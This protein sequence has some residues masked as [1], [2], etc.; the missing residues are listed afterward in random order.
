VARLS[1]VGEVLPSCH[2]DKGDILSRQLFKENQ[3]TSVVGMTAQ[4]NA[5][6]CAESS[7]EIDAE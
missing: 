1:L 7:A 4:T 5:V 2:V 6:T 3:D